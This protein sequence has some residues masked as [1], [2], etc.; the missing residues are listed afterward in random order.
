MPGTRRISEDTDAD[1]RKR[2]KSPTSRPIIKAI[3]PILQRQDGVQD[4]AANRLQR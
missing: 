3:I 4:A 1:A 2:S